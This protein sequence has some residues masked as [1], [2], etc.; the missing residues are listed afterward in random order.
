[1]LAGIR[2]P[3]GFSGDGGPAIAAQIDSPAAER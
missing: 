1:M 3:Q 2:S